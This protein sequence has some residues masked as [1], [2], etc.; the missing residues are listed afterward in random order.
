MHWAFQVL[1]VS[2]D[3]NGYRYPDEV[4]LTLLQ[5]Q[6]HDYR[7]AANFVNTT[8]DVE[9]LIVQHEYGIYGGAD[10]EYLL[11]LVRLLRKPFVLVAHTILPQPSERQ[12]QILTELCQLAAGI[13]CMTRQSAQM[14]IDLYV[15][16][17][18]LVTVIAHG[19]P[20]FKR[21]PG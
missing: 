7:R 20:L 15:A 11:E 10:G 3:D 18:D 19:V 12:S 13:V 14:L 6:K 2:D 1:A 8:P 17:P 4:V 9:L 16:P 21:Y 5:N